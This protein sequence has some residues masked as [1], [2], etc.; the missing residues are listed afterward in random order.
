MRSMELLIAK[1]AEPW[2]L[3]WRW[4][5]KILKKYMHANNVV[6][7]C[8]EHNEEFRNEPVKRAGFFSEIMLTR[9]KSVPELKL[10]MNEIDNDSIKLVLW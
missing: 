4:R 3:R 7:I 10:T 1:N 6:P 8:T 5:L 2:N 9:K